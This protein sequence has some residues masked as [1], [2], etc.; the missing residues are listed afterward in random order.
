MVGPKIT[1]AELDHYRRYDGDF[2]SLSRAQD[3]AAEAASSN[4]PI[5]DRLR[6]ELFLAIS[7]LAS[8]KYRTRIWRDLDDSIADET[9][10][11]ELRTIVEIDV[12]RA[13]NQK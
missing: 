5:I 7:G 1:K 6:Q 3:R 12:Y 11:A 4:W 9:V 8:E 10:K 13:A 2:D